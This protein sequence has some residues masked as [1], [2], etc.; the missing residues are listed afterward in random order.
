M[1]H[2]LRTPLNNVLGRA[3]LLVEE[4]HGSLNE[5]QLRSVESIHES[6][7][8][9]LELINDI[10][11]LSKIEA[12]K[13]DLQQEPVSVSDLCEA[14]IRLVSE[15]AQKKTILIS[16]DVDS[17]VVLITGDPRRLKQ[18]LV[19]LLSNAVKFTPV[20]GRV[21]LEVRGDHQGGMVTFTVWDTGIGID[22]ADMPRLFRPFEQLDS[23]LSRQYD[24]TGLGL[25]LVS[26]LTRLHGGGVSVTSVLGQG[27]RFI[28]T[29]PWR[30]RDKQG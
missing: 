20:G 4:I 10:L 28:V 12:D 7:R 27:S 11:D 25:S 21:G 15:A 6:G 1:S 2:E 18:I 13:L 14:S 26:R 19:N 16:A 3:E 9:L 30:L 24:G 29:L 5:K 22:E 17:I 23:R 8:H